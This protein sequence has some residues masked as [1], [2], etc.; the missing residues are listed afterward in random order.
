MGTFDGYSIT[1]GRVVTGTDPASGR[2]ATELGVKLFEN[3]EF[4]SHERHEKR[5]RQLGR[6]LNTARSA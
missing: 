6:V 1:S 5:N 2:S 3:L 4:H